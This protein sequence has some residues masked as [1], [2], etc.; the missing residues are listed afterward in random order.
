L[1]WADWKLAGSAAGPP[2]PKSPSNAFSCSASAGQNQSAMESLPTKPLVV[3]FSLNT[4]SP[5]PCGWG[6]PSAGPVGAV[7]PLPVT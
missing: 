1:D 6:W 2:E 7:V 3:V 5:S 4:H